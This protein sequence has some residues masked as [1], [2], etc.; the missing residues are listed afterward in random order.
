MARRQFHPLHPGTLTNY[1]PTMPRY[2]H[3][4][5][6]RGPIEEEKKKR[7]AGGYTWVVGYSMRELI[8]NPATRHDIR[9]RYWQRHV[10]D[11]QM[12][13]FGDLHDTEAP[14]LMCQVK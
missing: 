2:G 11:G 1:L 7:G 3:G 9:R 13:L 14:C 5:G 4:G 10:A 6:I 12:A 8:D